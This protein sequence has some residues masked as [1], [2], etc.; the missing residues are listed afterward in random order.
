[1]IGNAT[2]GKS[3][4]RNVIRV[5]LTGGGT[6]G[7]VIPNI[8]LIP[9]LQNAE[10]ILSYVASHQDLECELLKTTGIRVFQIRTGKLRRYFTL[11]NIADCFRACLGVAEAFAILGKIEPHVVFSKG[12]YVAL[13]VVIAAWLRRIPIV[14]HESDVSLGLANR[15]SAKFA[16]TICVTHE[17]TK[18]RLASARNVV[19]T[20]LPLRKQLFC[21][22]KMKGLELCGFTPEKPVILMIGGGLGS[23]RLNEVIQ[24]SLAVLLTKF[25]V[26]HITGKG[27]GSAQTVQGYR[28]FEF[29][30]EIEHLF[31]C[32]DVIVSRA[33]A[34][35]VAEI[36]ALKKRNVLLPLSA[37]ASRGDQLENAM[38]HERH[39][40]SRVILEEKLT[41]Q[42]FTEV[43]ERAYEDGPHPT[44]RAFPH[45]SPAVQITEAI[46]EAARRR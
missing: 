1:M 22:D 44:S 9:E 38:L 33:G 29:V 11:K 31:A 13:P 37:T 19:V 4:C 42:R 24:Q 12:G 36:M 28:Q 23:T 43:I 14:I 7:H 17:E 15:I 41:V 8:A 45:H 21:G 32:A 10:C 40:L 3:Q 2:A 18:S 39:G 27:K 35:A 30:N 26:I 16:H 6:A 34:T 5:V 20:G 25:Q 46:L